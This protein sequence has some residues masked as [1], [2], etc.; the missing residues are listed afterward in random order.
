M[1]RPLSQAFSCACAT[2]VV[3]RIFVVAA[4]SSIFPHLRE[5]VVEQDYEQYSEVDQAVWR[6]V[7][8][9]TYARLQHTAHDAYKTGLAATGISVERIPR[10]EE[11]NDKL[12]RWGW[13]A[14]CVDGFIPPRAFQAFQA[15]R[16]LPIAADIR[17]VAHLAYTPAPDIIHEAAGHAPI[18]T[19]PTY[20]R[21]VQ[22]IGE[23]AERAFASPAD[24]AVYQAIHD[25]SEVKENPSSSAD[26]VDRAEH[27]LRNAIADLGE[28]S[29]AAKIARLYWWTAEYG[30]VG[31]PKNYRL[32]GAGLLSSLGES[33]SCHDPRVAK[34]VLSAECIDV[35]YDIT[36]AQPQLFVARDF[37][38]LEEV[39]EQVSS[40]LAY[41]IGGDYALRVARA[42]HEVATVE[43]DSGLSIVGVVNDIRWLDDEPQWVQFSGTAALA[44][45]D[46]LLPGVRRQPDYLVPLGVLHDGVPLSDLTPLAF[47]RYCDDEV[48][49]LR[50]KSG[51]L[52]SGVLRDAR[53]IAGRI[54]CV[55]LER[56]ELTTLDGRVYRSQA[57]YPL[58]LGCT[59]R[60]ARAGAPRGFFPATTPSAQRVPK[61]RWFTASERQ[62][63]QLYEQAVEAWHNLAGAEMVRAFERITTELDHYFPDDWLLKW[64][65]LESLVK[66]AEG[67]DLATRLESE[68]NVMEA[69]FQHVEPIAIGLS[70][71]RSITAR[72]PESRVSTR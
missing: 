12:S 45:E 53:I 15:N 14:V 39:L 1:S 65:L 71:I 19:E 21:Y 72:P 18:L 44:F 4:P 10:I 54:A 55:V 47:A 8:L 66:V 23:V 68:L 11:M 64:N 3:E 52:I 40:G 67:P 7:L 59:V 42:S 57:P 16:L 48:V 34:H 61:P 24:R 31:T 69:R 49:T 2:F 30:L 26:V 50:L 70:Y 32:Y 28:P 9:Q 38:Q 37:G 20:A 43:L 5:Y 62:L 51:A 29:E 60:T 58:A 22:K 56:F 63:G 25:L 46:A 33:Q 36:R 17:T 35:D 27:V 6:F 41:R 13:G